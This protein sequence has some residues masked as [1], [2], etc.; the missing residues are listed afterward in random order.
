[1]QEF[2]CVREILLMP[3]E[4]EISSSGESTEWNG[5]ILFTCP[6]TVT[7]HHSFTYLLERENLRTKS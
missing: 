2:I 1:M 5:L 7:S 6:G 4:D 3:E